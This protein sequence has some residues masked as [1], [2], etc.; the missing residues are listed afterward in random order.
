[1]HEEHSE[2]NEEFVA[3]SRRD[4]KFFGWGTALFVSCGIWLGIQQSNLNQV[5]DQVKNDYHSIKAVEK[6]VS[7]VREEISG[8]RS[9]HAAQ[10]QSLNRIEAKIDNATKQ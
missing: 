2:D 1:M 6:E 4:I 7:A 9:S 8:M 10:Q 3:V 5:S